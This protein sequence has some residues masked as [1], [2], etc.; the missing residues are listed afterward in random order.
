MIKTL[1]KVA[2]IRTG[3]LPRGN[4]NGPKQIYLIQLKDMNDDGCLDYSN[5]KS[6]SVDD[7]IAVP[8][9]KEGDVVFKAKSHK[10]FASCIKKNHPN[11]ITATSHFLIVQNTSDEVLPEFV[12]WYLNQKN[13]QDFL[14]MHASGTAIPII[15]AKALGIL[16]VTIPTVQKQ[17]EIV[18]ISQLFNQEK[19]LMTQLVNK[20]KKLLQKVLLDQ[21]GGEHV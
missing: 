21:A 3:F 5:L 10:R 20:K 7:G 11:N 9:L 2:D 1:R 15:T 19:E 16:P 12:A 6:V 4:T 8:F 13:A 18:E 14:N 17:K